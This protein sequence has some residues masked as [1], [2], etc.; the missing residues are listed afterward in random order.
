[1]RTRFYGCTKTAFELSIP[2][3]PLSIL[4][5][6][7]NTGYCL[8][9]KRSCAIYPEEIFS[10]CIGSC[11]RAGG[12]MAEWIT[13]EFSKT[14]AKSRNVPASGPSAGKRGTHLERLPSLI[15]FHQH[16]NPFDL[17][18]DIGPPWSPWTEL[19]LPGP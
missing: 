17:G 8:W 13:G 10:I 9:E 19:A 6:T 18:H 3:G 14:G 11:L 7:T 2:W 12:E 4:L 5:R 16:L 15:V 1:M